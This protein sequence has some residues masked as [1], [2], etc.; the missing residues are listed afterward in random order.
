MIQL[1]A[2]ALGGFADQLCN[3]QVITAFARKQVRFSIGVDAR[4]SGK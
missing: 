4:L 3:G 2:Y 1:T